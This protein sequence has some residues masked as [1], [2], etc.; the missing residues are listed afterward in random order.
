MGTNHNEL[1]QKISK[2]GVTYKQVN[3]IKSQLIECAVIKFN[4]DQ[5]DIFLAR[6]LN[7]RRFSHIDYLDH[8]QDDKV[9]SFGA[10]C[11]DEKLHS[12]FGVSATLRNMVLVPQHNT[13]L[14][15]FVDYY[16][17]IKETIDHKAELMTFSDFE[18]QRKVIT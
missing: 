13:N 7:K 6:V 16:L 17:M 15:S 8:V 5:S 2:V 9:F 1:L 4:S 10:T 11:V 12:V 14:E 18:K 3:K